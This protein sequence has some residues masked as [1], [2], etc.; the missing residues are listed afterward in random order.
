MF[1]YRIGA[2]ENSICDTIRNTP[3]AWLLYPNPAFN[4]LNL[5]VPNSKQGSP[6][7]IEIFNMLGQL[8]EKKEYKINLNYQVDISLCNFSRGIYFLKATYGNDKCIGKFLKE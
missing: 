3:P 2:L 5:D 8:I 4:N 1:N 7:V 6:I